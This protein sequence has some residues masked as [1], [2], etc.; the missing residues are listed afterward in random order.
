[1]GRLCPHGIYFVSLTGTETAIS[2]EENPLLPSLNALIHTIGDTLKLSFSGRETP[3]EQLFNC[4][5]QKRILLILDNFEYAL[6]MTRFLIELLQQAPGLKLLATSRA[7]L[8]V[9]GEQLV[10]LEGLAYPSVETAAGEEW[11]EYEAVQLFLQQATMADPAFIP[12]ASDRA[13]ISR[14]CQLVDGLPLGVELAAGWVR[15]IS[16]QEIAREIE[17]NLSFLQS[18]M[19]DVPPRHQSL[20]AVFDYSWRMLT[21][22]EKRMLRQLSVFRGGFGREAAVQ[23]T[24]ATLPVL[25]ALIDNSLLRQAASADHALSPVRYELLEVLRQYAAEKLAEAPGGADEEQAVRDGHARF[26]LTFLQ[27]RRA[28]LQGSRQQEALAEI[29]LEIENIRAAWRWAAAQGQAPALDQALESLALFY[30]M[31][32]WFQEGE[33]H[34]GQA[35][36][37][38]AELQSDESGRARLVWAKLL[39]WQGWFT[40]LLGR[41]AAARTLLAQSLDVLR[42]DGAAADLVFPLNWLAVVTYNLGEFEGAEQLCQEGLAVS[43]ASGYRYGVAVAKNILS[44]IAY[45]QDQYPEARRSCQEALAIGREIGNRWSMAFSLTYLGEVAY[46]LGDYRE[47]RLRFQE[48]LAIREAMGD[49]RGIATCL[50]HLGDTATALESYAEAHRYYQASLAIFRQIG[51]QRSV[52]ASLTRLGQVALARNDLDAGRE[53]F[54][55]ALRTAY[56]VQAARPI[57]DALVGIASLLLEAEPEQGLTL[58]TLVWQ[59]PETSKESQEQAGDLLLQLTGQLPAEAVANLDDKLADVVETFLYQEQLV[60][61]Q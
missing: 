2:A 56:D 6:T 45:A 46:A 32:S 14:I 30:Y 19:R 53:Y 59:H 1:A 9:R 50:N 26:Y 17:H 24:G 38:L 4:L 36:T 35:A 37:R 58:A 13:A 54:Q 12:E 41:Q 16:C 23:V 7:R 42:P 34:F 55:E 3:Q 49:A 48:G 10:V 57:L 11:E 43:R 33:E 40:F 52:A 20:H 61:E 21:P 27:Q 28:E 15:L 51:N 47:A 22:A 44:Q 18:A 29:R 8:N 60:P 25:A 5:R 31:R 39:A